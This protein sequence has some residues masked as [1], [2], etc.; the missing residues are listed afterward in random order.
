V[1]DA[2]SVRHARPGDVDR[3]AAAGAGPVA[4]LILADP[5]RAS[6]RYFEHGVHY[7]SDERSDHAGPNG[8]YG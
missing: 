3:S 6:G 5:G 7:R 4:A 8:F 1:L 2:G